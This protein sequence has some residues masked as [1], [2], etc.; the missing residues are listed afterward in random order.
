[1]SKIYTK[2]GDKGDTGLY[3]GERIPKSDIR[4]EAYGT[5][6]ELNAYLGL[7]CTSDNPAIEK[8]VIFA[9]QNHLFNLGAYLAATIQKQAEIAGIKQED[10]RFLE[11]Q[12]DAAEEHLPPL[13]A[14][15]LPGGNTSAAYCHIAR[16]VCRRAERLAVSLHQKSPL[17]P[18]VIQYLNRLS[19]YLFVLS[20]RSLAVVGDKEIL[21]KP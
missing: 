19:D 4:V 17:K 11:Q 21:W 18:E 12:I 3:G 10:V 8:E 6:D 14:F 20:R 15:I 7:L 5:V 16:T 2:K 13:R 1:M 9:I